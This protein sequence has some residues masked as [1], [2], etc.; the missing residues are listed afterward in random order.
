MRFT[1]AFADDV[2][3]YKLSPT[4]TPGFEVFAISPNA[5][6]AVVAD[7]KG[8][9]YGVQFHPEFTTRQKV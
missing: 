4:T 2:T 3:P 5:S 8:N 1:V 6:N 9:F 7:I